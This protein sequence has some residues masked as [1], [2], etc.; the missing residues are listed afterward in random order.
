MS[1]SCFSITGFAWPPHVFFL[2]VASSLA[3]TTCGGSQPEDHDAGGGWTAGAEGTAQSGGS[4]GLGSMPSPI[5]SGGA[6]DAG[7]IGGAATGGV[8]AS[9]TG[10]SSA[11]TGGATDL[12]GTGGASGG[13]TATGGA[14]GGA[15]ATGGASAGGA[16][17]SG[18]A[19]GIG[20]VDASGGTGVAVGGGNDFVSDV[21]IE[22]HP[23]V[24]TILVVT[25]TQVLAADD[26]WL[27][28]SFEDGNLMTSR[29]APGGVGAHR[30]VVLG[31][32]GETDVTVRIVQ[33]LDG[34]EY[35]TSDYSGRTDAVPS[36]TNGMPVPEVLAC[37]SAL[38]SPDRWLFGSVENS[39]G[40]GDV[41]YYRA[42]FWLYIMDRRGRVVWYHADPSSNA[43]TSFQRRAR[44]GEYIWLEKRC[45]GCGNCTESVVKMTLDREYFEEIEVPS[46]S[47]CIDVT[48]QLTFL[49]NA[50]ERIGDGVG[51]E[52]GFGESNEVCVHT[53]NIGSYQGHGDLVSAGTISSGG[54]VENVELLQYETSGY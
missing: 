2:A 34:V 3:L 40:G 23:D 12:G 6:T 54:A 42:T 9:G 22:V 8:A 47:D 11:T 14:S 41:D 13:A 39:T 32:P 53:P 28:F 30:D 7:G 10:G 45:Y 15:V 43:T 51:N 48:C 27:E 1:R 35:R 31:V 24:N 4:G 46:L 16:T 50:Y 52:N 26:A 37:D 17:A 19:A 29:P 44:D 21:T 25:W 18:G 38:A 33:R 5:A 36:G 20:G 49:R